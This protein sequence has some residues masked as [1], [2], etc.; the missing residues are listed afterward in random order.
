MYS[1][2]IVGVGHSLGGKLLSLIDANK[3]IKPTYK[4]HAN[5]FLAYNNYGFLDSIGYTF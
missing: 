2:P 5:I 4:K 3:Q 1:V